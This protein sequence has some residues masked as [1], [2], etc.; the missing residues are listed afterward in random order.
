MNEC[1]SEYNKCFAKNVNEGFNASSSLLLKCIF[2]YEF[3]LILIY[4]DL[5]LL[6]LSNINITVSKSVSADQKISEDHFVKCT[7]DI[8][9]YDV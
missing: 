4:A 6:T 5:E 8:F 3:L 2:K 7:Y 9:T 1:C